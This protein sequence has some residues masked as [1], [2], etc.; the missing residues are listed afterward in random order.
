M[1]S[2]FPSE[3]GWLRDLHP[4]PTH[5]PSTLPA[6]FRQ[7]LEEIGPTFVKLGQ[8][9][10]TRPDLLPPNYI[11]ELSKLQDK[12]P[13]VRWP[14]I[15]K[16]IEMELGA[17]PEAIFK[18]IDPQPIAAA[19]LGQVHS[20]SLFSGERVVVKIQRPHIL[21][22]IKTDLEI[23]QDLARYMEQYT[24]LG[25]IYN[26]V[27]IAEDFADTLNSELNYRLEGRNAEHFR[28]NFADEKTVYIPR[29][30]WDYSTQRV[31]VLERIDGLKIDDVEALEAMGYNC[32]R[33][34]AKAARLVVKQVLEHGYFHA[35]PH[36]GNL[37]VMEGEIIGAMDF[38]MVGYLNNEDRLNLV[39]LYTVAI[40][41]EANS[42]VDELI[43]LGAAP[44][45]TNRRALIREVER[46]LRYYKGIQL[47]E[48]QINELINEIMPLAF[49]HHLRFPTNLWLLAKSLA[50]MEGIGL[51]LD[52]EFDIFA[53]S[54]PQ[55]TKLLFQ[56]SLPNRRWIEELLRRG[57]AWDELLNEVPRTGM[58][59]L[60]RL[61][62]DAPIKLTI[63]QP[64]LNRLDSIATRLALSIIVAGM[65][66][67][68]AQIIP[69]TAQSGWF[70]QGI[71]AA[72]FMVSF[73]LGLWL[74]Y[75]I[76][77][78]GKG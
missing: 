47:K 2:Q 1:L 68:L 9:L 65:I 32:K 46:L 49:E 14:E 21:P 60:E 38:G 4:L 78:R 16:V 36:P 12:V 53:F 34:A 57:L 29:V 37:I 6:H 63:A 75:L 48:V 61:Q 64:S 30:Y 10:S 69:V 39:R 58:L 28:T 54:A 45:D 51:K 24:M 67:G 50:I 27:D 8:M 56:T 62:Q 19:S 71:V 11:A 41:M 18:A 26:L 72:G 42:V 23:I 40:R 70:I 31:L 44:P 5:E 20:A 59:L 22:N 43:R 33:L 35:D 73:L 76:V 15:R 17:A 66:I 7:A 77:R 55:I 13:P 74:F 52:P 3:P 25:K